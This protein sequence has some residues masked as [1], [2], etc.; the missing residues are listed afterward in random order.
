LVFI[1]ITE[2]ILR[3]ANNTTAIKGK[4]TNPNSMNDGFAQS[5]AK[6]AVEHGFIRSYPI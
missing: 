2:S 4:V 6:G 1:A 3:K 5:T